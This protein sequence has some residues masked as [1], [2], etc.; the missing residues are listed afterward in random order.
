[1][2]KALTTAALAGCLVALAGCNTLTGQPQLRRAEIVPAELKPGGS[3]V[4]TVDIRDRQGVVARVEGV[5]VEDPRITFRLMDDG[6]EPDAKAG[7][8]VWSMAV[9][10]PFQAPP[11][12]YILEMTA[13]SSDGMPLTVRDKQGTVSPLQAVMPLRILPAGE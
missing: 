6:N 5:V 13:Y 7:D 11:G 8:G 1:M 3:A 9:D 10:V 2:K 12:A 4:I